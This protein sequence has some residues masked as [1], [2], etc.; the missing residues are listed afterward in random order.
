MNKQKHEHWNV[1]RIRQ[2]WIRAIV[3]W[4]FVLVMVPVALILGILM[5]ITQM[6]IGAVEGVTRGARDFWSGFFD[7]QLFRVA[8]RAMSGRSPS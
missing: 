1:W 8:W 2:L 4:L 7:A 3:T 5:I 6:A